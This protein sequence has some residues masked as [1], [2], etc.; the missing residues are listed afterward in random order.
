MENHSGLSLFYGFDSEATAEGR[1]FLTPLERFNDDCVV[2]APLSCNTNGVVSLSLGSSFS[3]YERNAVAKIIVDRIEDKDTAFVI[4]L[5]RQQ[6]CLRVHVTH[7]PVSLE[8][9]LATSL[10]H[11]ILLPCLV[12]R[13]QLPMPLTVSISDVQNTRGRCWDRQTC[14]F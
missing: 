3:I 5:G 14:R 10:I 6:Q 12:I 1:G 7:T 8:N 13:N 9:G 11:I 2:Y 4:T